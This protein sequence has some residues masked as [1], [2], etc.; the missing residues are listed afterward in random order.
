MS[1]ACR[2]ETPA[3]FDVCRLLASR[4][5]PLLLAVLLLEAYGA[6]PL[7]A[8]DGR[9]LEPDDLALSDFCFC[10]KQ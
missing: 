2:S 8:E 6:L 4:L 3:I 1:V 5:P 10:S 9:A 7:D